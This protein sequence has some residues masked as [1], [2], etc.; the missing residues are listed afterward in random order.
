MHVSIEATYEGVTAKADEWIDEYAQNG[1]I[2][3]RKPSKASA[4]QAIIDATNK[5]LFAHHM[6]PIEA[7]K[8]DAS[9]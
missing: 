1:V 7:D 5:I 9:E 8:D 3:E 4:R 2:P 6:K